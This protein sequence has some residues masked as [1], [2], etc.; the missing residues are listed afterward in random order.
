[1][2]HSEIVSLL[3]KKKEKGNI[4]RKV[5]REG[6]RPTSIFCPFLSEKEGG[7]V[8][9]TIKLDYCRGGGGKGGKGGG[10]GTWHS[11]TPCG[12]Q[13][14]GKPSFDPSAEVGEKNCDQRG[15]GGKEWSLSLGVVEVHR[16]KPG[17]SQEFIALDG[18]SPTGRWR[19]KGRGEEALR[20]TSELLSVRG[21]YV[22]SLQARTSM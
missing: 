10:G 6:V 9:T 5:K 14:K 3:K 12:D 22:C 8:H 11:M 17:M 13:K 15:A 21:V 19:K 1:M 20:K 7:L 18:W 16:G 2:P 4:G